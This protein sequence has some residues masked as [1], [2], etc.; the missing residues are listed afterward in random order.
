MSF[1]QNP[2]NEPRVLA[3]PVY[4]VFIISLGTATTPRGLVDP[5]L[6]RRSPSKNWRAHILPLSLSAQD[7]MQQTSARS[8]Q[9]AHGRT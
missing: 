4:R 7:L 6:S 2:A 9:E 3:K 5:I 8:E 1:E